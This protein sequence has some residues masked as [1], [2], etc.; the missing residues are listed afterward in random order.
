MMGLVV[1]ATSVIR[2][3]LVYTFLHDDEAFL[4]DVLAGLLHQN[5]PPDCTMFMAC[6]PFFFLFLWQHVTKRTE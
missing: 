1:S 6:G 4:D 5:T 2:V 3:W